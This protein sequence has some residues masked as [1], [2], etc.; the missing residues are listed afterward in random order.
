MFL[1][2]TLY[3]V[4]SLNYRIWL[5][6][7]SFI[8]LQFFLQL[9]SGVVIGSIMY[10]MKLTALTAGLLSSSF[11][12]I[13]TFL[14]IP[15][16]ILCDRKNP[17]VILTCSA[18]ICSFGCLIFASSYT[19]LSLFIGRF[20]IGVGSSFAFVVM[21]HLV[22][23][24][25]PIKNF[26]LLIGASETLSFVVTVIGII[27]M[28]RFI[29][30]WGWR[31]FIN[32]AS[33]IAI[34][35]SF[36]CWIY[37]PNE[38]KSPPKLSTYAKALKQI[39]SSKLLWINGLFLGLSFATITVFGALWAAP[40]LQIKLESSM[41]DSSLINSLLFLGAGIGCP[42]FGAMSSIFVKRK[43]LIISSCI[44]SALI[45][46]LI[47]Y[48]PTTSLFLMGFMMF[49]LGLC[50]CS[51]ILAFSISNELSPPKLNST[52]TGFTNSLGLVTAPLLQ[53]LVGF[54]LE[55]LSYDKIY[56]LSEYQTALLILPL[57]LVISGIL[58]CFLPEKR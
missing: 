39:V 5:V 58:A 51:Y 34:T 12:I 4:T 43:P 27:G 45:L 57:G 18:L 14:Q 38:K 46:T 49:M 47:I 23:R 31:G 33:I 3:S 52:C 32:S 16:G 54:M 25:Y 26:S 56:T 50:C 10:E 53:P 2:N 41:R 42:L 48:L 22:R 17:K 44:L 9:S 55:H 13:Y 6:C 28:G 29:L 8:L 11:Y 7:T 1:Q 40:F 37:I 15:V 21:I 24:H 35:I 20:L 30:H 36:L 19:I